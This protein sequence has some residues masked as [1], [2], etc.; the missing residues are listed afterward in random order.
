M[1]LKT[2][3]L[4]SWG[5]LSLCGLCSPPGKGET[6]CGTKAHPGPAAWARGCGAATDIPPH[7]A[8]EDQAA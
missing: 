4:S 7:A 8:G 2:L 1:L 3:S 6:V 5:Y